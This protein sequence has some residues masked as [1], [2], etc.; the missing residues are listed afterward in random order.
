MWPPPPR[1]QTLVTISKS[2]SG[3]DRWSE[4]TTTRCNISNSNLDKTTVDIIGTS[5]KSPNP[6]TPAAKPIGWKPPKAYRRYG[7]AYSPSGMVYG[8]KPRGVCIEW[9]EKTIPIGVFPSTAYYNTNINAP[10][11]KEGLHPYMDLNTSNRLITE[12]L[13]KVQN[14]K[15]NYGEALAESRKTVNHLA[16][17]VTRAAN[18]FL[19]LRRRDPKLLAKGL[20]IGGNKRGD[21]FGRNWLEYQYAWR[22]LM[23]D[24][25]DSYGLL[26]KGFG[27]RP[28]LIRAVRKLDSTSDIDIT[29]NGVHAKGNVTVEDRCILFYQLDSSTL[30]KYGQLGLINPLEVLWAITPYSFVIDWFLPVGNLLQALTATIGTTFVGGCLSRKAQGSR[31][32][33]IVAASGMRSPYIKERSNWSC[34]SRH[35]HFERTVISTPP[36]P[37]LYFKNPLST[38]HVTSAAALV[39]QLVKGR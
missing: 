2:I 28:Q 11:S 4:G 7:S 32:L 26:T 21:W 9:H 27:E 34:V 3:Y 17:A 38:T 31:T 10:F 5:G 6:I 19:G 22:P 33:D 36:L 13:I 15:V 8:E 39:A 23:S 25:Y 16:N 35:Q 37:G 29:F 14:R 24:I 20:G 12:C 30:A 1:G 18:I